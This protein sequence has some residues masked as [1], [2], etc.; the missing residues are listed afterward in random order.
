M[1][2]RRPAIQS[3]SLSLLLILFGGL[4]QSLEAQ[5][6]E[7]SLGQRRWK[8]D[9][10]QRE[11]RDYY[12]LNDLAAVVGLE[13]EERGGMLTVEGTRGT[14]LLVDGRP[15]LRFEDHYLLLSGP[16]WRRRKG[17][18]Y[19]TE[20]FLT[21]A[22]PLVVNRRLEKRSDRRYRMSEIDQNPVQVRVA[23]YPDHVRVVFESE[24]KAPVKVQEREKYIE[25]K[26]ERYLVQPK[27][28][29][30]LPNHR[31]VSSVGFD[32][33]DVYGPFRI[34]KGELYD[35]FRELTLSD[36]D[37]RV[38]DV[39]RA[40]EA[41]ARKSREPPPFTSSSAA[42]PRL[43][44]TKPD[45]RVAATPPEVIQNVITIDPG[46]GGE[47]YGVSS[48]EFLLEKNLTLKIAVLLQERLRTMGHQ[49]MLTRNRDVELGVEQRSS[50]GNY[51]DSR[52]YLSLHA[53]GSPW[54]EIGGPVVYV[55]QYPDLPE[56]GDR[57]SDT[58]S[59][60]STGTETRAAEQPEGSDRDGLVF[61]HRAHRKYVALSREL[62]GQLQRVLNRLWGTDNEVIEVPLQLLVPV[63][64]PAVLIE[65][66]FLTNPE[67]QQK[68][69]SPHFQSGIAA[70]I[71][72]TL[73]RFLKTSSV[74][75]H[76]AGSR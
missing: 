65:L 76:G 45:R 35:T 75:S 20:D 24:R 6:L 33:T 34:Y 69:Y 71:A 22:V 27:F 8:I 7:I 57:Q 43:W 18:W 40:S 63:T 12:R 29:T 19:V 5:D 55:H 47:D 72:S 70:T 17:D 74:D 66:G 51:Y 30:N 26:F 10:R 11:G 37:R 46:H 9:A 50:V 73:S 23:N 25:V 16:A 4:P 68:L 53:G 64:A 59:L 15:L 62:A 39:Y 1:L 60:S 52:L 42:A 61:W 41:G 32:S 54:P 48:F 2:S 49:G 14:L 67:D 44:T 38:I 21:E 58:D 13:L 56:A 31:V 36:P 28:P 3:F